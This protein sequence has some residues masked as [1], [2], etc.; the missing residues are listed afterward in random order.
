MKLTA[1]DIKKMFFNFFIVIIGLSSLNAQV[2]VDE[3]Q[4]S[5]SQDVTHLRVEYYESEGILTSGSMTYS[6]WKGK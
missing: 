2:I 1:S 6:L 3:F 5:K 4:L